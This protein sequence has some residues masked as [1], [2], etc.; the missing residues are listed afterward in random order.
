MKSKKKKVQKIDTINETSKKYTIEELIE[1]GEKNN[2][3]DLA[4]PLYEKKKS[5][6]SCCENR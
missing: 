2:R 1:L 3:I 5:E 6:K 4:K